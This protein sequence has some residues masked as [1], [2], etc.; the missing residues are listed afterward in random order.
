M[1]L[2]HGIHGNNADNRGSGFVGLA[3]NRLDYVAAY[4]RPHRIVYRDQFRIVADGG[5]RILDG[6][7]ARLAAFD[8]SYGL[9][10]SMAR[11]KLGGPI[12]IVGPQSHYDF[13][14]RGAADE[15]ADGVNQDRRA[16]E[17]HELLSAGAF[18]FGSTSAHAG[19]QA[20]GGDNDG[21][22]H[23]NLHHRGSARLSDGD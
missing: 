3:N 15:L 20:S 14:Y 9:R 18:F 6:M 5:E 19:A 8:R 1:H 4:K 16:T 2:L 7:L 12:Q 22:F 13:T 21:D 17:Q 23:P 11:K 10:Q